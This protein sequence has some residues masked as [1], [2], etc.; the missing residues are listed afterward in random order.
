MGK[1]NQRLGVL[2]LKKNKFYQNKTPIF[3]KECRY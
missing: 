3:S 1:K 2:K